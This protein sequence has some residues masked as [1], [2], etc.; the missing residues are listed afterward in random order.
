MSSSK[1]DPSSDAGR[2]TGTWVAGPKGSERRRAPRPL[3]R[4][5]PRGR[6]ER[7]RDRLRAAWRAWLGA[8]PAWIA[9]FL[10][11][12]TWSLLPRPLGAPP[13]L[14]QGA[15]AGRTIVAD[16]ELRVPDAERT[17]ELQEQAR[18]QVLPVYDLDLALAERLRAQL[19][20]LFADGRAQL[21]ARR[22]AAA[23]PAAGAAPAESPARR[24]VTASTLQL[25]AEQEAVFFA[26]RWSAELEDRLSSEIGRLLRKGVV[27]DKEMLLANRE[28]GITVHLLP[29][30]ERRTQL[31]LY[32][33]LDYPEEVREAILQSLRMGGGLRAGE[34]ALLADFLV[35]NLAPNL[36]LSSSET[37]ALREQAAAAVGTITRTIPKGQVIVRKG[38]SVD[39]L[40]ARALEEMANAHDARALLFSGLGTAL[41]AAMMVLVLWL[42]LAREQPADRSLAR[43]LSELLLLLGLHL[44]GMRFAYFVAEAIAGAITVEPLSRLSS[45][46]YAVPWSALAL[47]VALLYGRNVALLATF[48]GSLLAGRL[49]GAEASWQLVVYS[50]AGSLAA[51]YALDV[52]QFKQRTVTVTA[53][54]A[55]GVVN[56]V[57][58]LMLSAL[59]G[60][61]GGIAAL[62]F[63]LLCAVASGLLAA[64]VTSFLVPILEGLLGITTH[65]KLIELANPNLPLLRR[66]AFEAPGSFQHSLMVANL[67]KAG[68]EAIGADPVLVNTCA[69]YHDVG[70]IVRPQYF[71]ENQVPGQNPHDKIQPSMSA[72]ILINHVK[73]GLELAEAYRLPQPIRDAIAQHH[74]THLIK[75]F[76]RRALERGSEDVREEDFR[77]PGPKPQ[78]KEMGVLMLADAVEAASR[79][80]VEPSRQA[81]RAM[82]HQIFDNCLQDHQLDHTGLSLGELRRIEQ[83]FQR[84]LS[85]IYHRRVDYPG[86][87][88]NRAARRRKASAGTATDAMER[89]AS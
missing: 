24:L 32:V 28:H 40:A 51:I 64:A 76:Y 4:R 52:L 62:G 25:S 84:L 12:A 57:T 75:F 14:E 8:C 80:L 50:F 46:L 65:I 53:G 74:G 30:G 20:A 66:L 33:F 1:G 63:D 16:R 67:A 26:H 29:S 47:I 72:L 13:Q 17:R 59:D 61:A 36:T 9:F 69:L 83:A 15:V 43:L 6:L 37:L 70:K 86:F 2:R 58:V 22:D 88:F 10:L 55:A 81:I 34:R 7:A 54:L 35:A 23:P 68:C 48:A 49:A 45:Y 60:A 78:S 42:G 44:L 41:L 3:R 56:A 71:I 11:A 85:N 31:N 38:D 5:R 19:A 27:W 21:A 89:K 39:A 82:L 87:D 79:T 73:E 18:Q 77:Y